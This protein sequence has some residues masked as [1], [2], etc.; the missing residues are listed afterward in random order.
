MADPANEQATARAEVMKCEQEI[1][2]IKAALRR[3]GGASNNDGEPNSLEIVLLKVRRGCRKDDV[4]AH[5]HTH[6][7]THKAHVLTLFFL[8]KIS[9]TTLYYNVQVEGLPEAAKPQVALQLSSPVEEA[10]I[11]QIFDPLNSD[12]MPEGSVAVFRG[13]ETNVA[14]LSVSASDADI[15]LGASTDYDVAPLCALDA[16][17]IKEKYVIELQVTIVAAGDGKEAMI[18]EPELVSEEQDKA[19]AAAAAAEETTA[20]EVVSVTEGATD[21]A[22][23]KEVAEENE[24]TAEATAQV[25]QPLCTLTLRI[26]Y[27]PSPKD[28]REE[29]YELLNKTSQIKAAA[30]DNLRKISLTLTT[31]TTTQEADGPSKETGGGGVLAKSPIIKGGFLNKKKKEPTKMQKLYEK[32]FGPNSLFVKGIGVV[33]FARNYIIF[34]GASTFFHFK[35]QMLSLPPPV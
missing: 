9:Y 34:F 24:I 3:I 31:T 20:A 30:L 12:P 33:F 18:A 7:H 5:I 6:T 26:T 13:V 35:G 21:D 14:T 23:A 28:Q 32:T 22:A 27:K 10:T 2:S 19:A 8:F 16:M 15:P 4:Q 11:T 25:L 1:Q 17:D 29:L